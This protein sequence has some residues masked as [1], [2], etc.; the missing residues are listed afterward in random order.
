VIGTHC[1]DH[2]A[3]A[4]GDRPA[5]EQ[6]PTMQKFYGNASFKAKFPQTAPLI[7]RKALPVYMLDESGNAGG[8]C[9]QAQGR[10]IFPEEDFASDYQ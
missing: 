1:H 3:D 5:A 10:S 9:V 6:S 2:A 4:A 7:G 8:Q